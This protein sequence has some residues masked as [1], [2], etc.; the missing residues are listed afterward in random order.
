MIKFTFK[1]FL[2]LVGGSVITFVVVF[3]YLHVLEY[4]GI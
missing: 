2:T 4:F 3:T 1:D